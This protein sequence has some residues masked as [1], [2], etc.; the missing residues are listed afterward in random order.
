[1]RACGIP[2]DA[3]HTMVI[4]ARRARPRDVNTIV[5]ISRTHI[6]IRQYH[7]LSIGQ[8]TVQFVFYQCRAPNTQRAEQP[9]RVV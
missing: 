7:T 2:I 3:C 5:H 6:Y 4:A 9:F 1:M 8:L